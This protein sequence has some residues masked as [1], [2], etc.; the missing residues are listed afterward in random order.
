MGMASKN[1][2][3]VYKEHLKKRTSLGSI[4]GQLQ[5]GP[6]P[7]T[8]VCGMW[9]VVCKVY[10]VCGMWYVVCGMWYVVCGMWYVVCGCV[11]V[12]VQNFTSFSSASSFP[13]FIPSSSKNSLNSSFSNS[14]MFSVTCRKIYL[15]FF[16]LSLPF[17]QYLVLSLLLTHF[18][19]FL[20]FFF[21]LI[22]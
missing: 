12:C 14:S 22:F 11:V 2:F 10:V 3:R 20:I 9:Y 6:M 18:H 1:N 8:L 7:Y 21:F 5:V 4:T 19:L 13:L 15:Y 17:L 16:I